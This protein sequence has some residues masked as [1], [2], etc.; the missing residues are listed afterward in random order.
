MEFIDRTDLAYAV[1]DVVMCRAGAL[2]ISE[3]LIANKPVILVPSPMVAEDHQTHNAMALVTKKAAWIVPDAE[4]IKTGTARV[5]ELLNDETAKQ[6]MREAQS[7]L[8][9]PEATRAIVD[10][11]IRLNQK[12]A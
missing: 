2:T 9:R 3:I 11:I 12:A 10:E 1:A 7:G 8:A 6:Q 4:V 5:L